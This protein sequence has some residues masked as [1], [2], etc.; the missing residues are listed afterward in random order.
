MSAESHPLEAARAGD[1]AAFRQLVDP[2]RRGLLA[3][4]YRMCGSIHEAED[5]VQEA[6]LRAWSALGSFEARSSFRGWIYRIATNAAIDALRRARSRTLPVA[7]APPAHPD[8]ALAPPIAEP[9]WLEPY[10]DALLPDELRDPDALLSQRESVSFAFLQALQRLPAR[11]RAALLLKDVVG[12]SATEIADLLETSVPAVNSMIQRARETLGEAPPPE[13]AGPDDLDVVRAYVSA[14][15]AA[16]A[17]ALVRLL[18]ED[19]ELSMPPTPSWFRGRDAIVR[20]LGTN[21]LTPGAAGQLRGA[22]TRAN[23]RLAAALRGPDG[24]LHGVHV[25]TLREGKIAEVVAFM[26]P[27]AL[28]FF[29]DAEP[30]G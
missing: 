17:G 16:D 30:P 11:Q 10:P 22:V 25:V 6:M 14:F 20:W 12:S 8:A 15:A 2:H 9:V 19:A 24:A 4:C 27:A 29:E 26:D 7:Y 18:R 5:V 3:H 23:G 1:A 28:R 21:V 13:P